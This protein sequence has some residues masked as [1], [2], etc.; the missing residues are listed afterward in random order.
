MEFKEVRTPIDDLP[1]GFWRGY[2]GNSIGRGIQYLYHI[3]GLSIAE[4]STWENGRVEYFGKL[5][6][7]VDWSGGYPFFNFVDD[8]F[9][10]R[11]RQLLAKT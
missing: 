10:E 11:Q 2:K 9:N 3:C 6:A 5:L 4:E 7:T 1:F 8:S